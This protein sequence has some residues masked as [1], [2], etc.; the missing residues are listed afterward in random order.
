MTSRGFARIRFEIVMRLSQNRP[1]LDFAQMCV[2]PR[3]SNVSGLPRPRLARSRA[4]VGPELD[5]PGLVRVQLQSELR[6]PLAK[7]VPEPPCILF[8]FEPDDEVVSPAHDDHLSVRVAAAPPVD[9]QVQ[10][11]MQV[12]I[13]QQTGTPMSSAGLCVASGGCCW[14]VL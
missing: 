8:V 4:G 1:V 9:P 12:D 2:K 3:K 6:Q 11:I 5:Q 14:L 13:R 7:L 10:D